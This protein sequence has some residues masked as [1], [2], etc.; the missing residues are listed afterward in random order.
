MLELRFQTFLGFVEI[1]DGD[2]ICSGCQGRCDPDLNQF[3]D[4]SQD[5]RSLLGAGTRI[6]AAGLTL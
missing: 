5:R 1:V 2:K 6:S 4:F 3:D